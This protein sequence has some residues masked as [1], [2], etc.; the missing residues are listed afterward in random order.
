MPVLIGLK[1][2]SANLLADV[3]NGIKSG[4]ANELANGYDDSPSEQALT[5][6]PMPESGQKLKRIYRCK[7]VLSAETGRQETLKE[8][9]A[10]VSKHFVLKGPQQQKE[11]KDEQEIS[12][13]S[14]KLQQLTEP[15]SP[16]SLAELMGGGHEPVDLLES[17][18][19]KYE[20]D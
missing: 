19:G 14:Q 9:A 12:E 16:L 15:L 20:N 5:A 6:T 1:G 2:K 13:C 18:H 11:D 7:T 10:Q 3:F 8:F 4:G 17:I